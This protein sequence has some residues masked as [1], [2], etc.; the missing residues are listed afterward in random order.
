MP[1]EKVVMESVPAIPVT[2]IGMPGMAT[3]RGR[4]IPPGATVLAVTPDSHPNYVITVVS[5]LVAILVRAANV[6]VVTLLGILPT[7]MATDLIPAADFWHLLIKC[8]G[9]VLG[10]TVLMILKDIATVLSG[11]EK[12]FPLATGSV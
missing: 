4:A 2:V 12:K 6:Y 5:P 10:G 11:W 7:A 9:L 3:D 1:D 8:S